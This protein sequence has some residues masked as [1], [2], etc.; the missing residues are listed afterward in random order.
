MPETTANGR[1]PETAPAASD[2][3]DP[4]SRSA[5]SDASRTA[6]DGSADPS[7]AAAPDPEGPPGPSGPNHAC[8]HR[9]G[10]AG[11][12]RHPHPHPH[13]HP[14]PLGTQDA[15][16]VPAAARIADWAGRL[17]LDQV[18]SVVRRAVRRQLLDGVGC[19]LAGLRKD[20][21]RPALAVARGLGG[22]PEAAVPGSTAL[23][24]VPAAALATGALV[25]AL[26]FDDTHPGALV[27]ATAAVL[28]A[29]L[30][31]AQHTT[32][33]GARV[34]TAAAAGYETAV[35][36]GLAAP[37]RFHARGVHATQ[38]ASVFAAPVTAAVLHG[39][40]A[41]VL[42]HALGLAGSSAGGLLE[43][44]DAGSDTKTLHPGLAAHAGLVA[45]R[46]ATAGAE[47]PATVLEGRYGVFAALAGH[48]VTAAEAAG[49]LG[50]MWH[51]PAVAA[52]RHPCCRL[53][54]PALDA[55]RV[56]HGRL[57]GAEP[58]SAVVDVPPGAVPVVCEPAGPRQAPR[59]AYE[60]KFALPYST[61]LMLLD[62]R[63]TLD[64][65]D[66]PAG[67][68]PDAAALAARV[69]HRERPWPGPAAEAPGRIRLRTTDGS[70]LSAE[71]PGGHHPPPPTEEVLVKFHANAGGEN[72]LTR[73]LA[74]RVLHIDREPTLARILDL[75]AAIA[76]SFERRTP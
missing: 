47:G 28:P 36:V 70:E 1:D 34:L 25:H 66:R 40:S 62:G 64:S 68:R 10:A 44:L 63:V 17:T 22:P 71:V 5:P 8:A 53:M 30:S 13:G 3:R 42:T 43:F 2:T 15:E 45:L 20:A 49:D 51:A 14:H 57:A 21:A 61:A 48:P 12:Q 29:L 73:E 76:A 65:Y 32:A 67:A 31:T 52:K 24:G 55:A 26:D 69:T 41:P 46:L 72:A 35:R 50:E 58:A 7:G 27:H 33:T 11:H 60:A 38:V 23:I 54:H 56:L 18:P 37:Y 74:E 19:L 16:T 6:P 39:T 59:T 4:A 75:T 9:P